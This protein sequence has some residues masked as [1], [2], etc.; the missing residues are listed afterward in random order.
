MEDTPRGLA[1]LLVPEHVGME[2]EFDNAHAKT[3]PHQM[4]E[5]LVTNLDQVWR[6]KSVISLVALVGPLTLN[7]CRTLEMLNFSCTNSWEICF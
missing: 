4:G 5:P 3:R 6:N 2:R 7:I 1:G